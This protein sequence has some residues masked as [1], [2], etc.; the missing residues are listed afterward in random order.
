MKLQTSEK[1]RCASGELYILNGLFSRWKNDKLDPWKLR[2]MGGNAFSL[3]LRLWCRNRTAHNVRLI[4]LTR[5]NC[6]EPKLQ[7]LV[8]DIRSPTAAITDYA[9]GLGKLSA[10]G[11]LFVGA[12]MPASL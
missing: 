11:Q 12:E 7:A 2:G 4:P 10:N 3:E 6:A 1:E 9:E 8:Y 5:A